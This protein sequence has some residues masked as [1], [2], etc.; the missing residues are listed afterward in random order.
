MTENARNPKLPTKPIDSKPRRK[1]LALALMALVFVVPAGIAFV[2][3][4]I[5]FMG[6]VRT[7]EMG[8][9]AL[10]PMLNYLAVAAGFTC[11]FIWAMFRGMFHDVEAPKYTMLENEA[12]LD[13]ISPFPEAR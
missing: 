8:G 4:F 3:K 7:E 2:N 12:K 9:A 5:H 1:W 6:T 13:E 10:V 11:L